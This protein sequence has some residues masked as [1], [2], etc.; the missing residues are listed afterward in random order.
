L[1]RKRKLAIKKHL[2]KSKCLFLSP[3]NDDRLVL[4]RYGDNAVF[5]IAS[6]SAKMMFQAKSIVGGFIFIGVK[7]KQS[8]ECYRK[9][10]NCT[11]DLICV[12]LQN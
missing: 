8:F 1:K 9:I 5:F 12:K 6:F 7:T 3:T 2:P 11:K 10:Q 4:V